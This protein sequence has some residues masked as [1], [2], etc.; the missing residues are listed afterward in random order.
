MPRLLPIPFRITREIWGSGHITKPL[1][2]KNWWLRI[3]RREIRIDLRDLWVGL[4]WER[5]IEDKENGYYGRFNLYFC[6]V[7]ALPVI[8]GVAIGYTQD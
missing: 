7:P 1:K 8:I 3:T 5:E 4:Y 6:I 2:F